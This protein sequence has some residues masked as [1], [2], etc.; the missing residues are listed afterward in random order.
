[1][2]AATLK[3]NFSVDLSPLRRALAVTSWRMGRLGVSLKGR[4]R[5]TRFLEAERLRVDREHAAAAGL[6][7]Q[8]VTG[9]DGTTRVR[10]RQLGGWS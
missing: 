10:T 7:V 1:M 5:S 4:H 9:S 6:D 8:V 2:E 3:V